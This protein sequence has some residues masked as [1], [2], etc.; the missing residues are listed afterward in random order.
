MEDQLRQFERWRSLLPKDTRFLV[1]LVEVE[2]VP[3]F[4]AHGYR[5]YGDYPGRANWLPLQ[6]RSGEEWSTVELHFGHRGRPFVKLHF[7]ILPEN[8][9]TIYVNRAGFHDIPRIKA[10]IVD[11]PAFFTLCKG[12]KRVNDTVFGDASIFCRSLWLR[13][14]LLREV[15]ELKALSEWLIEF[16]DKGIP[17]EWFE[18]SIGGQVHRHIAMSNS[19]RLFRDS[20]SGQLA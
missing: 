5:R 4:L 18:R 15:A 1:N 14:K 2:I 6:R 17:R 10:T 7:A 3:L 20:E 8:C 11:A 13:R 19:S 9:R 12:R 16:L